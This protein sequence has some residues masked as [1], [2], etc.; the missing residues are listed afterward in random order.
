MT[1]LLSTSTK[2][3]KSNDSGKGY[4]TSIQFLSPASE[5]GWQL[6]PFRSPAC[7]SACLGHSSGMMTY[8]TS[9]QARINRTTLL[10]TNRAEYSKQVI[11]EIT[12][13]IRKAEKL[14]MRPAVRL[15]GDSD[16]TWESMKFGEETLIERFPEIQFYDYTKW[17]SKF[18]REIPANYHL[19]F[20]RSETTSLED[21]QVELDAGRNVAVVFNK[22]PTNWQGWK[23]IDGDSDDLRFLDCQGVIVGLKAKGAARKDTSGFVVQV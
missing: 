9:K 8:S 5:S 6:C 17:P 2:I 15:N 10:M 7:E 22:V 14:D 11:K 4:L 20:S 16:I 3:E 12:A 13:L 18:R 1:K 19:T 23:V 21:I